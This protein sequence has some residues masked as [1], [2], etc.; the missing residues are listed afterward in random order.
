MS[1][2]LIPLTKTIGAEVRGINIRSALSADACT[3]IHQGMNEHAVLVFREQPLTEEQQLAFS[4][5][6]GELESSAGTNLIP[7]EKRRLPPHFADVSNL[8]RHNKPFARD[9]HQRLFAIGN[10]LWHSDSSFK[11]VPAKYS[12]LHALSTVSRG[13]ETQFA[14]MAAAYDALDDDTRTEIEGL[15]CEHSQM[16]SRQQYGFLDFTDDERERFRPVLQRLVRVHPGTGRKTLF[17]ASHAGGILD[18]PKPEALIFLRDLIEHATQPG[19]V[20]THSWA[21]G[22]TVMWDNRQTM[23]RARPFPA[24]EARDMRRTTLVGEGPTVARDS[25]LYARMSS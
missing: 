25:E 24:D 5:S 19:F 8:D 22:D 10:R 17:L 15:V 12:I 3:A 13:G 6:L 18:W 1:V 9:A 11:V 16:Y 14:N 2:K 7:L 23:H 21:V 4:R 20:Y